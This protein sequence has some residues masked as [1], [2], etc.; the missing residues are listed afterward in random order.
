MLFQS[1]N[2]ETAKT[3]GSVVNAKLRHL[4][5]GYY[6]QLVQY[7]FQV[8]DSLYTDQFEA[9]KRYGL[10]NLGDTLQIEYV[11]NDPGNNEVIGIFKNRSEVT[12]HKLE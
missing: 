4:G 1:C 9:D 12:N 5:K 6:V 8:G 11:V 7:Q 3:K 2:V 10:Q